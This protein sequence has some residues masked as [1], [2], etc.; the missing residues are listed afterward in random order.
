MAQRSFLVMLAVAVAGCAYALSDFEIDVAVAMCDCTFE[1]Y[2]GSTNY[3]ACVGTYAARP[4]HYSTCEFDAAQAR[5]C[6]RAWRRRDCSNPCDS[7]EFVWE[8]DS[9]EACEDVYY[10]CGSHEYDSGRWAR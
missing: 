6:V 10:D 4:R 2:P 8:W 5:R 3:G 1:C 9:L 7:T